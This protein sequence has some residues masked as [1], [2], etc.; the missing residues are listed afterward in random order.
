[1]VLIA[2]IALFVVAGAQAV[3]DENVFQ[4]DGNASTDIQSTPTAL[5]DWD[6]LCK[7]NRVQVGTLNALISNSVTSITVNETSSLPGATL[8]I[9]IQIGSEQMTVTARSGSVN[10]FTYTV[11]RGIDGT[12]AAAHSASDAV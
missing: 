1:M 4:L 9:N 6:L 2:S 12:T 8:P 11:T 3:H 7:A 10:P 5:E